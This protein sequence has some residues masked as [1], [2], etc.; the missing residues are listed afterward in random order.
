[1]CSIVNGSGHFVVVLFHDGTQGEQRH[2]TIERRPNRDGTRH[3][4]RR[5]QHGYQCYRP[6]AE[7][8][9]GWQVKQQGN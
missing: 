9:Q 5:S 4:D 7:D 6:H 3:D 1:M 2:G 8:D